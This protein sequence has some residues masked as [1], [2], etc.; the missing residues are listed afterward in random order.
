MATLFAAVRQTGPRMVGCRWVKTG[1]A[2]DLGRIVKTQEVRVTRLGCGRKSC[3]RGPR[4]L[5]LKN[6]NLYDDLS[7]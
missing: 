5:I 4:G 1:E 7:S 2:G 3:L 6:P